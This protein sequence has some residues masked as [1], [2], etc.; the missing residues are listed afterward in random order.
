MNT[1]IS[2]SWTA[3]LWADF[4]HGFDEI[5]EMINFEPTFNLDLGAHFRIEFHLYFVSFE[6]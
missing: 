6:W 3:P 2:L 5:Y 4:E 1:E